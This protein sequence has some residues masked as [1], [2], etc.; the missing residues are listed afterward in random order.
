VELGFFV[1]LYPKQV[2]ASEYN[3]LF[4]SISNAIIHLILDEG[5]LLINAS[6]D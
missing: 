4:R 1:G 2:V 3:Y 5:K 6:E